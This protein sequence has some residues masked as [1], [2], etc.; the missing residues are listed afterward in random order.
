MGSRTGIQWTDATWNPV[1][2]CSRVSPGCDHCYA[3]RLAR[4]RLR[5]AYLRRL[6]VVDSPEN[7]AEP[8][9]VR[10]WPE[11]VA[12]PMEWASPRMVFVNSM[13]DLFHTDV[14]ESF[15]SKVFE[16]MLC[17]DRHVYQLLAKRPARAARFWK[18]NHE[19][20]GAAEIPAHIWIG[21]SVESAAYRYRID[22]LRDIPAAVRF[23]SCEPLLGAMALDLEGI[24][25]V[26]AGGESGPGFRLMDLSWAAD[27]RD[28][29]VA[30]GV[31]F[32]FKQV[33][34]LTPK[35]GGRLLD[36]REWNEMP[37]LVEAVA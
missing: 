32:F 35:A 11:R 27:I 25:W 5:D 15:I 20:L 22:Q 8:F 6:P 3:E 10:L 28:Q 34:G 37:A 12:Q 29:C 16:E 30:G 1:T 21:T 14:P 23:F 13:S 24:H 31:P 33:G 9:A 19:L 26:I 4:Y 2:G 36:G 17:V 18:R 7:R